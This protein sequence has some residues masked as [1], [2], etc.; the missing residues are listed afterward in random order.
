MEARLKNLRATEA[1]YQ[2]ILRQSGKIGEVLEVTRE[3]SNTRSQIEQ[4]VGQINYLSRQV[5]LSSINISLAQEASPSELSNEWRP[6]ATLKAAAKDT[7]RGLTNFIDSLLV[8]VVWLPL[9][10]LKFAFYAL[11]VYAIWRI[12]RFVYRRMNDS[13]PQGGRGV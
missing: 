11:I 12:A 1:Q 6:I 13:L 9:L 3:L 10:A 4:L 2:L 5:D 8:L 7:L